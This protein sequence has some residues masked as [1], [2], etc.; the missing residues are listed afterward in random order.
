VR[1]FPESLIESELFGHVRGAFTDAK[2]S[3]VGLFA[4]ASRGTLFLDEIGEMP[5]RFK[6]SF[7]G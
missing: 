5:L 7:S 3:K 1:R 6:P 4:A 2:L